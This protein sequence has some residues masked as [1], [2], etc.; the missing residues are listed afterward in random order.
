MISEESIK[1][2]QEIYKKHYKKEINKEE[3][4]ESAA[5]LLRLMQIIHKPITIEGLNRVKKFLKE[6]K[7]EKF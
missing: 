2:F 3:A 1:K 5:K 6:I 7:D 4:Y